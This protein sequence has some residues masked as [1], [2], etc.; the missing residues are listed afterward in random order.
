MTPATALIL[1]T[2]LTQA[3]ASA[4]APG[5]LEARRQAFNA[6]LL[7]QPSATATLQAW[8]D[9][10]ALAPGEKITARRMDGPEAPIP[11]DVRRALEAGA[12]EPL[13]HR[14]VELSCGAVVLSRADNWYRPRRLTPEMNRLLE[15]TDQPFGVVVRPLAYLRRTL[16]IETPAAGPMAA[17]PVVLRHRAVLCTP[18]GAPFSLVVESYTPEVLGTPEPP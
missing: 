2:A 14:R 8:C 5:A 1:G 3:W 7:S 15:T 13:V 11:P 6:E 17:P 9:R 16:K 18:D 4:W 10:H 12:R